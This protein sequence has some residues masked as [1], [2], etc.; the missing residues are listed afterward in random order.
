MTKQEIARLAKLAS[1]LERALSD[2]RQQ[3]MLV[4]RGDMRAIVAAYKQTHKKVRKPSEG[5]PA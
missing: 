3:S 2:R 1:L 4:W 5:G